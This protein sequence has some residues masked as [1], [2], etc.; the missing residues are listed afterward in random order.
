MEQQ[1]DLLTSS[2]FLP[3]PKLPINWVRIS[4]LSVLGLAVVGVSFYI[5]VQIGQKQISNPQLTTE[6]VVFPT[7][8]VVNPTIQPTVSP[9]LNPV[10]TSIIKNISPTSKPTIVTTT[11]PKEIINSSFSC[12]IYNSDSYPPFPAIG[13]VPLFVSLYPSGGTSSGV[14]LIG[15][16]WD[17]DGNGTWDSETIEQQAN[18]VYTSNGN[19]RPKFRVVGSNK[20]YGP[21]C[22]YPHEVVSGSFVEYQNDIISID[23]LYTEVT[24]SRSKQNFQYVGSEENLNN[25]GN[26][27]YIPFL[28][29]SSKEQF[30]AVRIKATYNSLF[31]F[32][33]TGRD[34]D[35]GTAYHQHL[36]I[37]KSKPNGTYEGEF[38]ITYTTDEGTVIKEAAVAKYKITLTD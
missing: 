15:F 1:N 33:E 26:R 27:I 5:G 7:Q 13:S 34:M 24:V 23:K 17:Y 36:F 9:T 30:T 20:E 37:D 3:S 10:I 19:F 29:V 32:Y 21:T 14:T 38:T 8:E 28:T 12:G 18:R 31:G 35:E 16:Q 6:L 22:T 2:Q 11:I 4:L 25:G